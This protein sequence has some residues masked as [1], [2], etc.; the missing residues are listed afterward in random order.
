MMSEI[1]ILAAA[2]KA[3]GTLNAIYALLNAIDQKT[4]YE[5]GAVDANARYL[6]IQQKEIDA[7]KELEDTQ[8]E[9][10]AA[11]QAAKDA[12]KQS[13]KITADAEAQA[14]VTRTLAANESSKI[15]AD[16]KEQAAQIVSESKQ[17]AS[18]AA[19]ALKQKQKEL[20]ELQASIDKATADYNGIQGKIDAAKDEIRAK[21]L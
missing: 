15:I 8:S 20:T 10:E 12:K 2:N 14:E 7:R 17:Q 18:L 4:G 9:L 16:A 11:K 6:I 5:Q 21:F 13:G 1:E 3:K 19:A